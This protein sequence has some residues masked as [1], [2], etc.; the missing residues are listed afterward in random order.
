VRGEGDQSPGGEFRGGERDADADGAPEAAATGA[1]E[2]S[3][4]RPGAAGTFGAGADERLIRVP[5]LF[6]ALCLAPG[7]VYGWLIWRGIGDDLFGVANALVVRDYLNLWAGGR[8]AAEGRVATVFA[9]GDYYAWLRTV[10]GDRLDL[11]TWSYPPHALLLA[12]PFGAL[13]LLTGFAAWTAASGL[14]LWGSLRLA[15]LASGAALAV[16]LGPAALENALA[17]QNGAL[18]GGALAAG[19]LLAGRRPV[20]AGAMLGLLSLKPQ[21][22]LLVPVCLLAVREFRGLAWAAAF[23][24]LYC[25]AGWLAFGWDAWV[26]YAQ[27]TAPFMR[28]VLEAPFGLAFQFGMP[29]PFMAARAAGAGLPLAYAAQLLVSLG[30][31][32]LAWRAWA[33]IGPDHRR[34]GAAVALALCLTP[35]AT[36]YA[37]SYDLVC[38]AV[39]C[40][41]LLSGPPEQPRPGAIGLRCLGL[42]WL[43]PGVAMLVGLAVAP[44]LGPLVLA[45]ASAVAYRQ[46]TWRLDRAAAP[47]AGDVGRAAAPWPG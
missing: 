41:L 5:V 16:A 39:A 43:W 13:P 42:A 22:G 26:G 28:R 18:T 1:R 44:G 8:L 34:R 46:A 35:L 37:H 25:A 7:A 33:S 3:R 23:G 12:L 4:A 20:L 17:G 6:L 19:L 24:A 14:F 47:G 10:F 32:A 36:P 2:A 40:A 38:V 15:G 27:V 45:A 21:L 9:P 29:T 30:A 31:A 11:H